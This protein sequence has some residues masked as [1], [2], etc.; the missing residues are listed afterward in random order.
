[1]ALSGEEWTISYAGRDAVIAAVGGGLREL[2]VDG[3]SYI[4]GY[5]DDEVAPG[6]AGHVL[7]PWPGR[8]ADGAYAYDGQTHRVPWNEPENR[9]ALHGLVGW[10]RWQA[11]DVTDSSVTVECALPAQP[12]YP[13][14]LVLR[15]R[16]SIGPYGL[17]AVHTVSNVGYRPCPFGLG[18]HPYLRLPV[19]DLAE[20]KLQVP[21]K[22]QLVTDARK[23]PTGEV[24]PATFTSPTPIG[25]TVLDTTFGDVDRDSDSNARL[26]LTSADDTQ[27][28]TVWF[29]ESFG[30]LHL[31]TGDTLDADRRRRS[32]AVEPMTCPPDALRSGT[33]LVSLQ[34]GEMWSGTWG[35]S[36]H[37]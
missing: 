16:W 33:D 25:S 14:P 22:S 1:M 36:P 12:G 13:F 17:R 23:L 6:S 26:V 7:A 9:C 4:H 27:G 18:I 37:K 8:L 32:L 3:R 5:G 11:A 10:L 2:S 35:I 28:V 21:A 31:Y 20:W 24:V 15:T 34:P 29:D 19:G 30:W